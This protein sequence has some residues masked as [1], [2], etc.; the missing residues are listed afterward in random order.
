MNK[1]DKRNVLITCGMYSD[2]MLILTDA[3]QQAIENWCYNYNKEME[4]GEN[5]YF[6]SLQKEYYVEVLIDS[7]LDTISLDDIEYDEVYD[8]MDYYID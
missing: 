2:Y 1:S 6:D 3:T 4:N 7:E 8:M 5:T